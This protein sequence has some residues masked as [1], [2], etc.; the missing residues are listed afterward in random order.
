[1]IN[2]IEGSVIPADAI[3]F[4]EW[5]PVD[6]AVGYL[7]TVTLPNQVVRQFE[8]SETIFTVLPSRWR[9]APVG[10]YTWEVEALDSLGTVITQANS[11]F[12]KQ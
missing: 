1:M 6:G 4:F 3:L 2:P 11:N 5:S 10:D 8:V 9:G 7:L 12:S